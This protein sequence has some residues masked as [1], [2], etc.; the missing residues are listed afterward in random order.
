MSVPISKERASPSDDKTTNTRDIRER[1]EGR[2][3][4]EIIIAFCGPVGCNLADV[5]RTTRTQFEEYGYVTEH[6]KISDII[7]SHYKKKWTP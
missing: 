7:K 1:I 2:R 6:I 4:D 3:S 5:I